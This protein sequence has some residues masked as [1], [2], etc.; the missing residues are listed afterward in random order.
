MQVNQQQ[1]KQMKI[2]DMR[3]GEKQ[4]HKPKKI[5]QKSKNQVNFAR[6]NVQD[7]MA[8]NED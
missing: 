1:I 4:G 6:M 5:H 8:M 7:V 2:E 3:Y